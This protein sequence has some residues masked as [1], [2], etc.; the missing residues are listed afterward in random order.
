MGK[1]KRKLNAARK[2]VFKKI[3]HQYN[4]KPV[5]IQYQYDP[6]I[7]I[8]DDTKLINLAYE[9]RQ[10]LLDYTNYSA[11]PLCEYLDMDNMINYLEWILTRTRNSSNL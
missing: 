8:D 5:P 1:A 6:E 2:Q 11:Y 9:A 7:G 10:T 3:E 4:P